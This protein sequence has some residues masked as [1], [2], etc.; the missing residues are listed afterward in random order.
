MNNIWQ[1]QDAKSKFSEM[2]D[3]AMANGVQIVTKRGKKA[4]AV[5]SNEEYEH[6]TRKREPLSR[7]LLKSPLADSNLDLS[8]DRSN[9]RDIGFES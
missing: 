8:R 9:P 7:F 3:R 6:L 5:L 4:V 2:I 1:L